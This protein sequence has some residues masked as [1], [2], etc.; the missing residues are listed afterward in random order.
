MD[1]IEISGFGGPW[2]TALNQ[3]QHSWFDSYLCSNDGNNEMQI[4]IL[5]KC[6]IWITLSWICRILTLWRLVNLHHH[7]D[8]TLNLR[9]S[10]SCHVFQHAVTF[11]IDSSESHFQ[12][13]S[14]IIGRFNIGTQMNFVFF[15]FNRLIVISVTI[16]NMTSA[17]PSFVFLSLLK[18]KSTPQ[19]EAQWR[20]CLKGLHRLYNIIKII[21]NIYNTRLYLTTYIYCI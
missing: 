4:L 10:K 18:T 13:W 17:A 11:C 9:L 19:E 15:Q 20:S 7:S 3:C 14:V 2:Y 12:L 21:Y 6:Q 8:T 16:S 1:H 5:V